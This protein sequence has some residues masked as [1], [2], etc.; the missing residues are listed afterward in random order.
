MLEFPQ[1][2]KENLTFYNES[3]CVCLL[4]AIS[5]YY[6]YLYVSVSRV[7]YTYACIRALSMIHVYIC[8]LFVCLLCLCYVDCCSLSFSCLSSC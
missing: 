2:S 1:V 6:V 3:L 8:F 4:Y 5:I 7:W